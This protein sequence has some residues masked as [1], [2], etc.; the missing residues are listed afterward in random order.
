L[1]GVTTAIAHRKC[2]SRR[3]NLIWLMTLYHKNEA[4]KLTTAEKKALQNAIEN[5]LKAGRT[6]KS[7]CDEIA[8]DSVMAERDVF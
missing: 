3:T 4:A 1:F 6:R 5:E 2:I 8:E 7:K